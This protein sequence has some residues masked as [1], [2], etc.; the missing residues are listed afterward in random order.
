MTQNT[1][2]TYLEDVILAS[3]FDTSTEQTRNEIQE[4]AVAIDEIAHELESK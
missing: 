4:Q 1:V 3:T 2:E